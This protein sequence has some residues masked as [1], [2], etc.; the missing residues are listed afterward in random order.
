MWSVTSGLLL[1]GVSPS[2]IFDM[3]V[4]A[5]LASRGVFLLPS[6]FSRHFIVHATVCVLSEY[7]EICLCLRGN[8]ISSSKTHHKSKADISKSE[9]DSVPFGFFCVISIAFTSILHYCRYK[10]GYRYFLSSIHN[11]P[12]HSPNASVN[13]IYQ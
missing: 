6:T 11:P 8:S 13:T 1:C 12:Q 10:I 3:H 4:V 2:V 5:V 7:M 9:I